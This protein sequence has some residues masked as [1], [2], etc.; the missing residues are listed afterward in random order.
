MQ[1]MHPVCAALDVHKA[2]VTACLRRVAPGDTEAEQEMLTFATTTG[3]LERLRDWLLASGAPVVAMESTGVYW[4]PVFNILEGHVKV[5]VVNAERYKQ[6]EGRKTDRADAAW[7]AR[8]LQ[9]GLLCASFVPPGDVRHLRDLTRQRARLVQQR[10]AVANRVQ[11]VL[12]DANIKLGDVATDVLGKSGRRMLEAIVRGET[13]PEVLAEMALKRLRAKLEQLKLALR[14][15][16]DDHHRFMLRLLLD[17]IDNLDDLERRSSERIL[18]L[19]AGPPAPVG[20]VPAEASPATEPVPAQHETQAPAGKPGKR[21]KAAKPAE[22]AVPP[23][24]A[25]MALVAVAAAPPVQEQGTGAARGAGPPGL[26]EAVELMRTIPGMKGRAAEVVLGEIGPDMGVFG[27]GERLAS[28]AGL[29]PGN[30]ESAGKRFS[31]RMRRGNSHL[32]QVLCQ[33]AWAASKTRGSW[34]SGRYKKWAARIGGKRA[35]M[36]LAHKILVLCHLVLSRRTPYKEP[37]VRA[38]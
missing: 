18:E 21:A 33:A 20:P 37:V 14:G 26:A 15:K 25:L 29:C 10:S 24:A 36:A 7:L 35:T 19:L 13:D 11:K 1:L 8:L 34:L 2:S 17:Q 9:H 12:E 23:P 22:K 32:K 38:A 16:V 4:K 5:L 3:E 28:W 27:T 31:G 6:A 30:N